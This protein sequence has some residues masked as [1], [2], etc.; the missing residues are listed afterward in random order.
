MSSGP[1]QSLLLENNFVP[2]KYC[3]TPLQKLSTEVAKNSNNGFVGVSRKIW[4]YIGKLT[5]S[6]SATMINE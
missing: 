3:K 4:I 5:E 6:I 1:Q 2:T